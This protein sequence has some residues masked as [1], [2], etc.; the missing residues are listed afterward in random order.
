MDIEKALI[1]TQK[2]LNNNTPYINDKMIIQ[3]FFNKD[4]IEKDKLIQQLT[5]L[6]S[7]YSTNMGKRYFGIEEIA[8]AIINLNDKGNNR[9]YIN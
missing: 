2:I 7:M 8:D 1:I 5:I 3:S 4:K 9:D 6:D